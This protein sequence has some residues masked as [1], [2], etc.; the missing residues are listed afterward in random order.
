MRYRWLGNTGMKVSEIGFGAWAIGGAWWGP[1][2]DQDSRR[3]LRQSLDMGCNF[4][5]TAWVYGNGH[6]EKLIGGVIRERGEHPFIATKVPPKNW[7]WD[8]RSGTPLSAAFPGDWVEAKAEESLRNLGVDRLDVLQLHTWLEEWNGQ[9]E[10]LLSAVARLKKSGKIRAFGISLRDKGQDEANDLVRWRQVDTLQIFFNLVLPGTPGKVFPLARQYGVGVIARVP[11]A[12]GALSGRF[13]PRTRFVGDDHR[14][15]LYAGEG[16]AA[17]LKKTAK[18][19]FLSTKTMSLAEA[20]LKWTLAYPDVSTS[21]PGIRNLRQAV[22]NCSAGD[23]ETLT[24][25]SVLRCEKL[26]RSNFALPVKKVTSS[27]GIPAVF[28]SGVKVLSTTSPKKGKGKKPK[29]TFKKSTG[30]KAGKKAP[31]KKKKK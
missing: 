11:L 26:Y 25:A 8:N 20:A 31:R 28:F 7:N 3:A 19:Q 29:E 22:L 1:Q 23:G 2:D 9:A 27:E 21:I 15:N 4:I 6:S 30:K 18:L 24:R 17:T 12:F 14:R 16:L 13:N 10:P 5:D